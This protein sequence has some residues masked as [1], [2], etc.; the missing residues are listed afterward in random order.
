MAAVRALCGKSPIRIDGM[1]YTLCRPQGTLIFVN[2]RKL[3][4]LK[5]K[6]RGKKILKG[7]PPLLLNW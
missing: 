3:S 2:N 4:F 7:N 1:V 5:V 6:F